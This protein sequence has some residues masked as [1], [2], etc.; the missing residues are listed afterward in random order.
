[1]SIRLNEPDFELLVALAERAGIGHATL[2]R[3]IVED[4]LADQAPR[5]RRKP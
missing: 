1:M 3:R 5:N 4:W 2:A